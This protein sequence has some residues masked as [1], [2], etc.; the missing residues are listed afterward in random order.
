MAKW[1]ELVRTLSFN[2]FADLADAVEER[3]RLEAKHTSVLLPNG[4]TVFENNLLIS[5]QKIPAIKSVMRRTG[6]R[7]REAKEFCDAA[8]LIF[9]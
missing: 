3:K 9:D 7:L 6:K 5:R 4:L 2:D 8:L 1:D